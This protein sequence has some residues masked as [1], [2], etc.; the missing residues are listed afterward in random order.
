MALRIGGKMSNFRISVL[1]MMRYTY[2]VEAED[3]HHAMKVAEK[4]YLNH[5][6]P[7]HTHLVCLEMDDEK[8]IISKFGEGE[9]ICGEE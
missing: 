2:D 1:E 8:K 3:K 9:E 6:D 5:E 4:R 7:D